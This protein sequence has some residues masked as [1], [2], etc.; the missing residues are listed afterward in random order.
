MFRSPNVAVQLR[1][2]KFGLINVDDE[3]R[4]LVET[5]Y[6]T[7]LT[8]DKAAELANGVKDH[9]YEEVVNEGTGE[10]EYFPR[11][12]IEAADFKLSADLFR[13]SLRT[14][15]DMDRPALQIDAVSVS[16]LRAKKIKDTPFFGGMFSVTCDLSELTA[17]EMLFLVQHLGDE[18]RITFQDAQ[19]DLDFSDIRKT[20]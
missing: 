1:T 15:P 6:Y 16:K 3:A 10:V 7:I 17:P 19:G 11:A 8:G 12:E 2:I 18:V 5:V 9:L 20:A 13:F 14:A 4:R